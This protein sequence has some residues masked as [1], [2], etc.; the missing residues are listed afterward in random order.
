MKRNSSIEL[1]RVLLMFGICLLHAVGFG[2]HGVSWAC[3][4]LTT[5][6]V[7]FVF[8]S[9]W[10]GVRFSWWKV[11]K[12]YGIGAYAAMV[13]GSLLLITGGA[14]DVGT[15]LAKGYDK[16]IHGFW[17]LH[18]YALM[19]CFAPLVNAAVER[20]KMVAVLPLLVSVWFWGFGLT[21]PW[22]ET[23]LPKTD[24]LDAY[25]GLTLTAIYAAARICREWHLDERVRM[26]WLLAALPVLCAL[27]GIGLGD[28]NSPF[29]F[30]LAGV[31]FLLV[32]HVKLPEWLGRAV[33]ALSPS[34]FAVYLMHTNEIGL[35]CFK[36]LEAQ[37]ISSGFPIAGAWFAAALAV[38][39][40]ACALDLPRRMIVGI[41]F[42][43][44]GVGIR[45]RST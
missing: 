33:L 32:A 20:G 5:C 31:C 1:Y 6:V 27:T 7:G 30:A 34:M 9:G 13:F 10:F 12:L 2:G 18:A 39:T 14:S 37:L 42:R 24:G 28:Y 29:A 4:I 15:A 38:F 40:C 21:L 11:L 43:L 8:I 35:G 3:N 26:R 45:D 16:L 17:F 41:V 23:H 25:G 19:M 22:F 36:P 44:M